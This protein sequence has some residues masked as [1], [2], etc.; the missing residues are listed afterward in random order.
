MFLP[1]FHRVKQRVEHIGEL[2]GEYKQ[3][4]TQQN[5]R[6]AAPPIVEEI[7][8]EYHYLTA[9]PDELLTYRAY[10]PFQRWTGEVNQIV[11][12]MWNNGMKDE[13]ACPVCRGNTCNA[14]GSEMQEQETGPIDR[15]LLPPPPL[16]ITNELVAAYMRDLRAWLLAAQEELFDGEH[17]PEL[18][19]APGRYII[20]D[21]EHLLLLART[22]QQLTELAVIWSSIIQ[23]EGLDWT[24]VRVGLRRLDLTSNV[25]AAYLAMANPETT[26]SRVLHDVF[27]F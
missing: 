21:T 7:L 25:Q 24:S 9:D 19:A 5:F 12:A 3:K 26:R 6:T 4:V 18:P 13:V 20:G 11:R 27:G 14:C 15:P 1:I 23:T 2:L 22:F 17:M 16:A 10:R 8:R